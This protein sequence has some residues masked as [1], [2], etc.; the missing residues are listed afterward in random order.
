MAAKSC[1]TVPSTVVG[2]TYNPNRS[3][4]Q[5]V[6]T[7]PASETLSKYVQLCYTARQL[8][9]SPVLRGMCDV[10]KD[11]GRCWR[12][13]TGCSISHKFSAGPSETYDRTN[14]DCE[15]LQGTNV[16]EPLRN[17][18]GPHFQ[19]EVILFDMKTRRRTAHI[20]KLFTQLKMDL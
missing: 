17:R 14:N 19:Y 6:R 1:R 2:Q 8:V 18:R 7:Q 5:K 12:D 11:A 13:S 9:N 3:N 16:G 15:T 20:I 10:G 4:S